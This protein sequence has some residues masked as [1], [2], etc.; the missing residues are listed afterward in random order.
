MTAPTDVEIIQSLKYDQPYAHQKSITDRVRQMM[1][2]PPVSP[3]SVSSP[4]PDFDAE[5]YLTPKEITPSSTEPTALDDSLASGDSA[6]YQVPR[7]A[8]KRAGLIT[9]DPS[10]KEASN[11]ED[12]VVMMGDQPI[13]DDEKTERSFKRS[14]KESIKKGAN[15]LK[16]IPE[17]LASRIRFFQEKMKADHTDVPPQTEETPEYDAPKGIPKK[18]TWN[19]Y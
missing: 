16:K 12:Y 6:E 19:K 3:Q 11:E 8:K 17:N 2:T 14:T 7:N 18:S 10:T 1:V 13:T 4:L 15:T 5:P 9:R